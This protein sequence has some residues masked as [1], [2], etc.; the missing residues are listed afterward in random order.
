MHDKNA[1]WVVFRKTVHNQG[2]FPAVCPQQEWEAMERMNPGYHQLV[3]D[4]VPSEVE[5]EKLA[6]LCQS[7]PITPHV[8]PPAHWQ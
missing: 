1:T 5:A 2:S 8:A 4:D 6:R 3:R 7:E